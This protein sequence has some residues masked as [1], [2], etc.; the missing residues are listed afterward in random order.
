MGGRQRLTTST[1][2]SQGSTGFPWPSSLPPVTGWSG[3]CGSPATGRPPVAW[4]RCGGHGQRWG[5]QPTRHCRPRPPRR[6]VAPK[7]AHCAT[8]RAV[9]PRSLQPEPA[10]PAA[11]I[12]RPA[13]LLPTVM[14]QP[15]SVRIC[16]AV[17]GLTTLGAG[18]EGAH[19]QL[20]Y[21]RALPMTPSGPGRR[22]P[23]SASPDPPGRSHAVMIHQPIFTILIGDRGLNAVDW[24][25]SRNIGDQGL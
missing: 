1:P 17:V 8:D 7:A 12:S 15:F 16:P 25:Y 18:W 3:N 19:A 23:A 6:A 14:L 22:G 4:L 24:E 11:A 21:S 20:G 2:W 10:P 9:R 5:G 13:R